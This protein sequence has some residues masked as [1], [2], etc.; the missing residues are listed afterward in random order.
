L[1]IPD[2]TKIRYHQFAV[3]E[4]FQ[5]ALQV[6]EPPGNWFVNAPEALFEQATLSPCRRNQH[7]YFLE[8]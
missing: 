4:V 6:F 7:Q 1:G 5:G 2:A 8:A 3:Q